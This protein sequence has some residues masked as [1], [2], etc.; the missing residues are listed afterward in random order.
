MPYILG[1]GLLNLNRSIASGFARGRCT[2]LQA[3]TV[4]G[5]LRGSD[6]SS[7]LLFTVRGG[8]SGSPCIRHA[9]TDRFLG[10]TDAFHSVTSGFVNA[11]DSRISGILHRADNLVD[12]GLLTIPPG[13]K[14]QTLRVPQETRHYGNTFHHPRR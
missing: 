1:A 14:H 3:E 10:L 6:R 8:V 9:L 11:S 5:I 7:S 2:C 13:R 12:T 4:H